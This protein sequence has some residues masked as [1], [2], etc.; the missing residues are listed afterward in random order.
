MPK[1]KVALVLGGGAT[2]FEESSAASRLFE[3]DIRLAVNNIGIEVVDP[4]DYWCSFHS[5]KLIWWATARRRSGLP[6][7][8]ELWVGPL[9]NV[10]DRRFP[11]KHHHIITPEGSSAL[12]AVKVAQDVAKASHIVLCGVPLTPTP[13]WYKGDT[14]PWTGALRAQ[15]VWKEEHALG[16]LDNVRS[17]G[18]WTAE[19]LG[20]PNSDWLG[21]GGLVYG[22]T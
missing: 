5:Q 11:L 2:V 12:L 14:V 3:P 1:R 21:G 22:E 9:G 19:L 4:L 7:A 6:D 18:G 17:W 13:H 20:K 16:K 8:K 15:K 10:V